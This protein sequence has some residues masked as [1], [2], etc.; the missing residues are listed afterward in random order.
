M[1]RITVDDIE[2]CAFSAYLETYINKFLNILKYYGSVLW[3]VHHK[4]ST[5]DHAE[6]QDT[7]KVL[8]RTTYQVFISWT[9]D[10][11]IIPGFMLATSYTILVSPVSVWEY[12]YRILG[13]GLGLESLRKLVA[14]LRNKV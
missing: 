14:I 3:T 13:F 1:N 4:F 8:P 7:D 9:V 2:T 6:L 5:L 12:S 11:V 10:D